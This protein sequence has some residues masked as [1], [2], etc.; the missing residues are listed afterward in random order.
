MWNKVGIK[1]EIKSLE[2]LGWIDAMRKDTFQAGMFIVNNYPETFNQFHLLTGAGANWQNSSIPQADKLLLEHLRT[3][4]QAKRH[5]LMKEALKLVYES[6]EI[7]CVY[8]LPQAVATHK[9]VKG[10]RSLWRCPFAGEIWL[11]S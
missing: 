7:A 5:D 6:A 3:V 1:T 4:D 2:R 10:F 11:A 8:A 9:K